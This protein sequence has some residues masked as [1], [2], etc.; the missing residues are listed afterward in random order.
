[1]NFKD[2]RIAF[3]NTILVMSALLGLGCQ[4]PSQGPQA[5]APA[6]GS[7]VQTGTGD[8]GGG[9]GLHN[10]PLDS[11]IVSPFELEAYK[12]YLAPMFQTTEEKRT[13]T[14]LPRDLFKFKN[15]YIADV[16]L[17][18]IAKDS[19]GL[20]FTDDYSQQMA[21]QTSRAI[22]INSA[23]LEKMDLK[24]QAKL[25]LHE[26]VMNAYFLKFMKYSDICKMYAQAS[27]S[28]VTCYDAIDEIYLPTKEEP[29]T[30]NDYENIRG[31][32]AW[33]WNN[34]QTAKDEDVAR[35]FIR[36]DFDKR[37][38][39][40]YFKSTE[41]KQEASKPILMSVVE[42]IVEKAILLNKAPTECRAL[43]TQEVI[44]C[45]LGI[46]TKKIPSPAG[47]L[48]GLK[49]SAR[50]TDGKIILD[51]GIYNL[52]SGYISKLED[53]VTGKTFYL[54]PLAS[55]SL[56]VVVKGQ[57]FRTNFL[58][59]TT[60]NAFEK[61]VQYELFAVLSVAGVITKIENM[62]P[63]GPLEAFSK[64][65]GLCW[66]DRPRATSMEDDLIVIVPPGT[67][68]AYLRWFGNNIRG[69]AAPCANEIK[70]PAK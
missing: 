16:Q 53:T 41:T 61:E 67:E 6:M 21:I 9:N 17:K 7:D 49:I 63:P 20:S 22:W 54:I 46:E 19:L 29:L 13:R 12:K 52:G 14:L 60:L 30:F 18:P 36:Y 68:T 65:Q 47:E 58:I 32:T 43:N 55:E 39:V 70:A 56:G 10:R 33:L 15:W 28:Q 11:Y 24:E 42:G 23:I 31:M 26:Y 66:G 25:I 38:F 50:A 62:P 8:G 35:E 2:F 34:W 27:T 4:N 44:N 51:Q 40:S 59:M 1:M 3:M 37:T 69:L 57:K 45:K 5:A 64:F 48:A